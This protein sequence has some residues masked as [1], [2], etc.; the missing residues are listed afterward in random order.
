[1]AV[2]HMTRPGER[3][4]IGVSGGPDSMALL[5]LLARLAPQLA[6]GLGVAHLNHGLRGAAADRDAAQV[7]R[8]AAAMGLVCH[9]GR[10]RVANVRRGLRLSLEA[11]AHR[12]R[13]AF[14]KKVMADHGYDKLALGHHLDDNAE[15]VLMALLRGSGHRGLSG[16]APVRGDR[17]IRPLIDVRRRQIDAYIARM[18]IDRVQDETNDDPRMLRNR[19]RHRLL[20][21]LADQYN[22][23][24]HEDLNRLAEV[25][26][27]EEQWLAPY[28]TAPYM[29]CI[30]RRAATSLT[31]STPRL[32]EAHRALARRLLRRAIEDLAGTLQA[33]TFA[34]VEA[35]L[36][37]LPTG[38]E[39][40]LNLPGGIRVHRRGDE[41]TLVLT[42]IPRRTCGTAV[43]APAAATTIADPFPAR[44]ECPALGIGLCFTAWPKASLPPW[45]TVDHRCAFLDRAQLAPPL[46][47]RTVSPGDRFQP[48]GA[49]GTQKLKKYFIDHRVQRSARALAAVLTDR[50]QIVWLVGHRIDERVKVTHATT[51]VLKVEFFLLDTR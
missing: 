24:I 3:L 28:V 43:P 15:Q 17:I 33:I 26:R 11:A 32:V 47:L 7:R 41:L 30:V 49:G 8:T 46:T 38:G 34:H 51:D 23:R 13:Y 35:V 12:V 5:H 40:T 22:P 31:L 20:P 9:V 2:R 44:M 14:F 18:G 45:K 4:L 50:R 10:A 39:K 29:A 36:G 1:M 42:G 37:L 6:L 27:T 48:L 16:I 19:I 25:I 21:L